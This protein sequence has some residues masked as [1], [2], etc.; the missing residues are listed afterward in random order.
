MA[1]VLISASVSS[2]AARRR[3]SSF[4]WSRIVLMLEKPLT[5]N[6]IDSTAITAR[7]RSSP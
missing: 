2:S 5:M 1:T 7:R 6:D 3:K 4:F